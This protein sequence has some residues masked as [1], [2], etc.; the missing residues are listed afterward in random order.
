[1][2]SNSGC[3]LR[4]RPDKTARTK[5]S[6]LIRLAISVIAVFKSIFMLADVLAYKQIA[7][8]L[9]KHVCKSE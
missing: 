6:C 4:R 2:R 3:I 8:A 7:N 5:S 1:M 9:E